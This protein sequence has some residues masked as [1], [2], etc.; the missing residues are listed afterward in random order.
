M[1]R[2][3]IHC[4]S[5]PNKSYGWNTMSWPGTYDSIWWS[6][7]ISWKGLKDG[8]WEVHVRICANLIWFKNQHCVLSWKFIQNWGVRVNCAQHTYKLHFHFQCNHLTDI[9]PRTP[10]IFCMKWPLTEIFFPFF[11]TKT[12]NKIK[13]NTK[14]GGDGLGCLNKKRYNYVYIYI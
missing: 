12:Q 4:Y 9:T 10:F 13:E 5:G 8:K 14:P 1:L 7:S 11:S 3:F 6:F 2:L